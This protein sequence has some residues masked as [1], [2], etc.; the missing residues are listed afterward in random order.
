MREKDT[1]RKTEKR[2]RLRQKDIAREKDKER[3][4]KTER[5]SMLIVTNGGDYSI[6]TAAITA[7]TAAT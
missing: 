5:G 6:W 1:A 4:R 2:E 3:Q 7:P